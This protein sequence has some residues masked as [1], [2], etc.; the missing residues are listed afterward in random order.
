MADRFEEWAKEYYRRPDG[1]STGELPQV[2]RTVHY[3][4]AWC[5]SAHPDDF[6]PAKLRAF[7]E[8][9]IELKH[10]KTKRRRLSR[11]YINGLVARTKRI[12]KWAAG[13]ELCSEDIYLR[14][15]TV[16]Q[17]RRGRSR[18]RET[19]PRG[20]VARSEVDAV[21]PLVPRQIGAIIETM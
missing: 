16:E 17:L 14:L 4:K 15:A 13:R 20:P 2:Q 6:G 8:H 11:G 10:A 7:R 3:L 1:T 21:L 12:F 18:A 5:G 9:L 19:E